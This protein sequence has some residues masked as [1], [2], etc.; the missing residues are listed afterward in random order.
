MSVLKLFKSPPSNRTAL[1]AAI[2]ESDAAQ[3]ALVSKRAHV[4]T[5]ELAAKKINEPVRAK[6]AAERALK[7]FRSTWAARG[8][9]CS[10][11]IELHRLEKD[12]VEK[13]KAAEFTSSNGTALKREL[14]RAQDSVQSAIGAVGHCEDEITG[15]IGV[16]LAEEAAPLLRQLEQEAEAYRATRAK[17]IGVRLVLGREWTLSN[18]NT[19]NP[20][21]L[22]EGVI[23]DSL[24]RARIRSFDDEREELRV[25]DSLNKTHHEQEWLDGLI[26][27]WRARAAQLRADPDSE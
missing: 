24:R 23:T 8:A 18:K 16:I 27:P 2:A 20:A 17:V 4:E 13:T 7:E 25:R 1:H 26:A 15:A 21:H 19:M 3:Q 11:D 9:T 10:D 22:G 6:E 14:A 5:L 12:V